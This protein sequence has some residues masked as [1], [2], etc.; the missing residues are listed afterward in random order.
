ML[1]T[2]LTSIWVHASEVFRYFVLVMPR[3]KTFF[4]NRTGIAEM[5]WGIFAIWGLWDTLLTALIVFLFWL[6]AGTFGNN[7]KSVLVS[8]TLS[9]L[10]FFVLFWIG[11]ANMGTT[12]WEMLLITLPLSWLETLIAAYIASKL[13]ANTPKQSIV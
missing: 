12:Y 10:F 6:Y 4:E 1:I 7:F 3:T 11:S 2:L 9:W 5:S 8:G 13:Y